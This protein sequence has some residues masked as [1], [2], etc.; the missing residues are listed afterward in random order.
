LKNLGMSMILAGDMPKKVLS[1][2]AWRERVLK[3]DSY[4]CQWADCK[5][6]IALHA[7]HIKYKSTHPELALDI[8]NGITLCRKHHA[9]I[10]KSD[11]I[12]SASN[13]LIASGY[14]AKSYKIPENIRFDSIG[15]LEFKN[16]IGILGLSQKKFCESIGF[17]PCG[18]VTWRVNGETPVWA[19]GLLCL[20]ESQGLYSLDIS[21]MSY[22][23]MQTIISDMGMTQND[24]SSLVGYANVGHISQWKTK[25]LNGIPE[26]MRGIIRMLAKSV[27]KVSIDPETNDEKFIEKL[28]SLNVWNISDF[29]V[30]L[31][32]ADNTLWYWRNKRSKGFPVWV[33]SYI[34]MAKRRIEMNLSVAPIL[35]TLEAFDEALRSAGMSQKSLETGM[36]LT[37][38]GIAG[39]K[40]S[41]KRGCLRGDKMPVWLG[42]WLLWKVE[43][44]ACKV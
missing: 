26:H 12:F 33:S 16:S 27:T 19:G 42:T 20:V 2:R 13:G 23:E 35:M 34:E 39:I 17:G 43:E 18:L 14:R 44:S 9:E 1:H 4:V 40:K 30:Q 11:E 15:F 10:H 32:I 3:R 29:S 38:G 25:S 5:S 36:G 8:D 21:D 37:I 31:G 22:A 41:R 28:Y 24:F 7:H 6:K